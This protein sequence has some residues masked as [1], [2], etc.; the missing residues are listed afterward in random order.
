MDPVP[1]VTEDWL[2]ACVYMQDTDFVLHIHFLN[3]VFWWEVQ[4]VI[5]NIIAKHLFRVGGVGDG[6][7]TFAKF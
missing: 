7:Q 5:F 2:H 4:F 1:T 3:N 6:I